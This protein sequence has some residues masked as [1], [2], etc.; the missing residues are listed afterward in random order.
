MLQ[1]GS[2]CFYRVVSLLL[3]RL[4]L[5]LLLGALRWQETLKKMGEKIE[6]TASK[7]EGDPSIPGGTLRVLT[8]L[9]FRPSSH[10]LP[11]HCFPS[12][13]GATPLRVLCVVSVIRRMDDA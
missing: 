4:G 8:C 2:M 5:L 9:S 10:A 12:C 3:T 6:I 7:W 1:V 13:H 11:W